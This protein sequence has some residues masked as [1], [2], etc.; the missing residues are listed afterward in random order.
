M[1]A[2]ASSTAPVDLDSL[3]WAPEAKRGETRTGADGKTFYCW[4]PTGWGLSPAPDVL[5]AG[6]G[7]RS[8]AQLVALVERLDCHV[9]DIRLDP[10]SERSEWSAE[11][12]HALL[13]VRYAHIED[14]GNLNHAFAASDVEINNLERGLVLIERAVAAGRW[15]LLLC[16]CAHEPRCHRSVVSTALRAR[17]R[18]V[19]EIHDWPALPKGNPSVPGIPAGPTPKGLD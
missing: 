8:A 12:L 19:H 2:P 16:A 10:R 11:N 14:L 4:Y 7:N 3:V 9:A 1:S 13:S 5:T 17:G 6:Y 18:S 15:P